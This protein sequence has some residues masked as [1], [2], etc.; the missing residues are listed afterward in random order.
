MRVVSASNRR[1]Y[2]R[3]NLK[4]PVH[5]D[6]FHTGQEIGQ[7]VGVSNTGIPLLRKPDMQ[8]G[9]KHILRL[10]LPTQAPG[11]FAVQF[12][13]LK[14]LK[15]SRMRYQLCFECY[16]LYC[17]HINF[18]GKLNYSTVTLLARLRGWSTSRPSA[19]AL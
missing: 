4:F 15:P 11:R 13:K 9:D 17:Q 18:I 3:R 16:R 8:E 6:C 10:Y 19:T 1:R 12:G 5:M 7:I 14:T 2:G